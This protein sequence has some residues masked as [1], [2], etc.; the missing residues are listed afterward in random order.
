MKF[1]L[2]T[3]ALIEIA[4]GNKNFKKYL[5]NETTTLK[6]N[7]AEL[8]YILLREYGEKIA[9]EFLAI[10]SKI[11]KELPLTTI[12]KAMNFRLQHKNKNG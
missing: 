1:F 3:Y 5:N 4:A 11:V 9:E 7:L 6:G 2:D 10:F 12:S 8:Y